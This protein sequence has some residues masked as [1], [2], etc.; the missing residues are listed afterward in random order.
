MLIAALPMYDWAE[1]RAETDARWRFLRTQLR[2]KGIDAPEHLTRRNADMP[3]VP[4]GIRNHRGDLIA[5]DPANLPPDELNLDVLWRHPDLLLSETCWGPLRHGLRQ[6]VSLIGQ[7]S[8]DGW[9]GG[10]GPYYS[11][12]IIARSSFGKSVAAHSNGEAIFDRN[13]LR[14]KRLAYNDPHS[15]SGFLALAEDLR[16]LGEENIFSQYVST[17]AHRESIRAVAAGRAD[18]A[19]IDCRSWGLAQKYETAAQGL[20]VIGWTKRRHGIALI[21]SVHLNDE[22]ISCVAEIVGRQ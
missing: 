14:E 8:Y 13:I 7:S 17:G 18:V 11:S 10:Q 9:E 22:A 20:H 19:A 3:P 15:L 5:P 2:E 16:A 12:A 1:N 4:G 21:G 6:D